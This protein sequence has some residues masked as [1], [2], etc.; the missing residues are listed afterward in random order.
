[1]IAGE[2]N[3]L[4][5]TSLGENGVPEESHSN[6]KNLKKTLISSAYN[7]SFVIYQ[8]NIGKKSLSNEV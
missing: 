3:V 2:K 6:M 8:I 1:M 5:L 4:T 7:F